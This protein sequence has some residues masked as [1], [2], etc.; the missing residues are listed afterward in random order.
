MMNSARQ[1]W[2]MIVA[3]LILAAGM[4]FMNKGTETSAEETRPLPDEPANNYAIFSV[5]LPEQL[6]FAGEKVPLDQVDIRE[7]LDREVLVNT[8]WQSQTL[9]FIKRANRFF[10]VIEKILKKYG[11]P[12]DFKYLSVAESGLT[13]VVSPAGAV[14]FW[15]LLSATAKENGL[16]V[17]NEIDERYNLEKS[18][19]AACKYFKN[20]PMKNMAAGPW[21][22]P[23]IM[24]EGRASTGRLT[25]RMK[26]NTTIC[27]YTRRLPGTS[28]GS[29]L[30]SSSCRIP[31]GSGSMWEKKIFIPRSRAMR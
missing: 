28:T 1:S 13:N 7:S 27:C 19:E 12:D 24:P 31:Q 23:P 10:P 21:P 11:I 9:L 29:W 25:G 4:V 18:T 22:P 8:Y 14:G 3:A 17:D 5:D 30:I 16:E 2:M 15:Q 6:E 26:H 20:R